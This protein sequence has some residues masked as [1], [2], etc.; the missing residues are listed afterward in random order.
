MRGHGPP[1]GP[2]EPRPPFQHRIGEF[3]A[4]AET[5]AVAARENVVS[6]GPGGGF[7]GQENVMRWRGDRS[8][9]VGICDV[10]GRGTGAGAS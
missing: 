6:S 1:Q 9:K 5:K 7:E 2:F 8:A 10:V 3:A 4:W